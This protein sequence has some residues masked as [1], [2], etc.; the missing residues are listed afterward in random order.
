MYEQSFTD[1][2]NNLVNVNFE[3][4]TRS[5]MCTFL[6]QPLDRDKLCSASI[7]YGDNCDQH[8]GV[9]SGTGTGDSVT[10][11]SLKLEPMDD[12]NE[13]CFSVTASSGGRTVIVEG[14]L[15]VLNFGMHTFILR[16][17]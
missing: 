6:N 7:A 2:S 10:T 5:I 9:Y 1:G 13:Y 4:A 16:Q 3:P 17:D 11:Q 12:V 14:T 15:D 8:L